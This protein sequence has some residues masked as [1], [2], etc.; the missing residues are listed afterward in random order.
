MKIRKDR[1][2]RVFLETIEKKEVSKEQIMIISAG[3][4][5]KV[6]EY[7]LAKNRQNHKTFNSLE[8]EEMANLARIAENSG[9]PAL[10]IEELAKK[11]YENKFGNIAADMAFLRNIEKYKIV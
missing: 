7:D 1:K 6:A 2:G 10:S 8:L 4:A 5:N 9:L 11:I 3:V